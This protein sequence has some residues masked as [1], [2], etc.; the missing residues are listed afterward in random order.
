MINRILNQFSVSTKIRFIIVFA[1]ML[2]LGAKIVSAY[3]LK[4][5]ILEERNSAAKALVESTISQ[6][7]NLTKSRAVPLFKGRELSF[8]QLKNLALQQIGSTRYG[9]NGY[10]WVNDLDGNMLMHPIKPELNEQNMIKSNTDYVAYA[11]KQ[12]VTI[13]DLKGSGFVSYQWPTPGEKS[14]QNKVSF[15]AKAS[16]LPWVVGTG[17]YIDDVEDAFRQELISTA[18]YTALFVLVLFI[19]SSVIAKNITKPLQR[20]TKTMTLIAEEKDLSI[21]MKN[22]GRDELSFMAKAFNKMNSNLRDVV[23]K[24]HSNTDSLASQAEELSCVS[25]QIQ[26]GIEEQKKQTL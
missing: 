5:Q 15:V 14:L 9:E 22:T 12:F 4:E 2:I 1:S 13:A 20:I 23:I 18:T 26:A 10:L 17:V 19:V 11:F 8:E 25:H 3:S 21:S 6:I 16:F 7:D 24:I